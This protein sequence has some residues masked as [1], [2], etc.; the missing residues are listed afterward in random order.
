MLART[1]FIIKSSKSNIR[2]GAHVTNDRQ[3]AVRSREN[4]GVDER[5]DLS[6]EV[7]AVDENVC[8]LNNLSEGTT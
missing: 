7:D 5:R 4:F 3:A 8:I 2:V 1:S 6:G